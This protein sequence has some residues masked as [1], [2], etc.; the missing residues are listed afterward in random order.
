M[1]F[2]FACSETPQGMPLPITLAHEL[3]KRIDEVREEKIIPYLRPDGKSQVSIAYKKGKPVR[4]TSVVLAVPHSEEKSL[5]DVKDDLY[6][7][8]VL[9]VLEKYG[10]S[11]PKKDVI[12]NG[13]G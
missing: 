11:F 4:V 2:G 1:M 6:K 5:E 3:T 10:F 12:V 7:E 9:P 13:T 8:V